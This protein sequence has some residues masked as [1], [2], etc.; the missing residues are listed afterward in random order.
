MIA[1]SY[2]GINNRLGITLRLHRQYVMR[3]HIIVDSI[4]AY[5]IE[6]TLYGYIIITGLIESQTADIK[7]RMMKGISR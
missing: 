7:Q 5:L 1:A 2:L 6:V 3:N 4:V